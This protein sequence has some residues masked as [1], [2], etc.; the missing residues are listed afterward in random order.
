MVNAKRYVV[1][2]QR[3]CIV[4][5]ETEQEAGEIALSHAAGPETARI[6]PQILTT[7]RRRPVQ[8]PEVIDDLRVV[9]V[10]EIDP[11]DRRSLC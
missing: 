2:L 7:P 4:E 11:D 1:T 8:P 9:G 6:P 10:A 3:S 5:A